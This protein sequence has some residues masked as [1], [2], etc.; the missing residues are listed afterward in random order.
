MSVPNWSGNSQISN[1]VLHEII[2]FLIIADLTE[3]VERYD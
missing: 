1:S 2:L 3:E